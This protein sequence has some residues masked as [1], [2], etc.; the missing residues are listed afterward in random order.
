MGDVTSNKAF[1]LILEVEL[2]DTD[3][4]DLKYYVNKP[5]DVLI[6]KRIN[7]SSLGEEVVIK[8]LEGEIKVKIPP[9][10]IDG[11]YLRVKNRGLVFNRE[12]KRFRSDLLVKINLYK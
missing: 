4:F 11:A 9:N 7:T 12:G 10:C 6:S 8:S 3:E 5:P 1:D 2:T